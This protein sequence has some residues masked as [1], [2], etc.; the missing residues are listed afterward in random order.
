MNY[1]QA[2][3]DLKKADRIIKKRH[4]YTCGLEEDSEVKEERASFFFQ[5]PDGQNG[6]LF[7]ELRKLGWRNAGHNAEYYWKVSKDGVQISYTEGDIYLSKINK[8]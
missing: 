7:Y 2:I 5:S 4:R 3:E 8:D 6:E 1:S